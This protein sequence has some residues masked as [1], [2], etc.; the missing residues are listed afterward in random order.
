MVKLHVK[1]NYVMHTCEGAS[2][3]SMAGVQMRNQVEPEILG[4]TKSGTNVSNALPGLQ[5]LNMKLRL[6]HES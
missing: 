2:I 1:G 5:L 6:S 4:V 3:L